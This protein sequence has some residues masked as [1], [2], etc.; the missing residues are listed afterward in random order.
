M[1]YS[2]CTAINI[3]YDTAS[4]HRLSAFNFTLFIRC[5]SLQSIYQSVFMVLRVHD[6]F[7]VWSSGLWHCGS[8]RWIPEFRREYDTY[9]LISKWSL[10]WMEMLVSSDKTS[11]CHL[12]TEPQNVYSE[13]TLFK[14][15]INLSCVIS[16]VKIGKIYKWIGRVNIFS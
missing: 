15:L 16:Y 8:L 10:K 2:N 14:K 11:P 9:F 1:V 13:L 6:C 12:S 4:S 7:A 5:T 3:T